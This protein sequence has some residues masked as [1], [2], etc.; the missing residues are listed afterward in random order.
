MGVC[1]HIAEGNGRN[2]LYAIVWAFLFG[3]FAVAGYLIYGKDN[4][5]K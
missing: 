5:K 3:W 1:A 4:S 2:K